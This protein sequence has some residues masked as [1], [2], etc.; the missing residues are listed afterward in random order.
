M[1]HL[2]PAQLVDLLEG[3]GTP[4]SNAHLE[5]CARCRAE[6]SSLQATMEAT[7]IDQVPELSPFYWEQ[8]DRRVNERIDAPSGG[9]LQWIR[10]PR[11]AAMLATA[12]LL[13]VVII[14]ARALRVPFLTNQAQDPATAVSRSTAPSASPEVAASD[15]PRDDVEADAAWAV[16]RTAAQDLAYEDA[17]AEGITPRPG[18]AEIAVLHMSSAERAELARLIENEMKRTGA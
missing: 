13:F 17:E 3:S 16:V 2:D 5:T 9:W 11:L 1:T 14:G 4:A 8:F 6:L 10:P 15:E 7:A 18:S 12:A